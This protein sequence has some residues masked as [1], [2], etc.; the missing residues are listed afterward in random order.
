MVVAVSRKRCERREPLRYHVAC[1]C[2]SGS[3]L[4]LLLLYLLLLLLYLLLL[5]LPLLG[6]LRR[7]LGICAAI[8]AIVDR[9]CDLLSHSSF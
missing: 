6:Q 5:L 8:G 1:R 9:R 7:Q 2:A 3:W 4:W